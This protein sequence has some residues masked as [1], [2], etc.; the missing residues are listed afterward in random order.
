ML[1]AKSSQKSLKK[2]FILIVDDDAEL[3]SLLGQF[4][5]SHGFEV[6]E[7]QNSKEAI[8]IL[9]STSPTL[10]LLDLDIPGINGS[11]FA[12]VVNSDPKTAQKRP[13]IPLVIYSS[14][15]DQHTN[16]A[17]F[18]HAYLEK[19][20]SMEVLLKTIEKVLF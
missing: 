7:A 9:K 2:A 17:S 8:D 12:Q 3:R 20:L 11:E 19:P 14:T 13:N 15:S 5:D 6:V 18:A 1:G 16:K 4:L 10:I